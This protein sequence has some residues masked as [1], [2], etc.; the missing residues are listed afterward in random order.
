M[1]KKTMATIIHTELYN[2]LLELSQARADKK[3]IEGTEDDKKAVIKILADGL[4]TDLPCAV[5][6]EATDSSSL[7]FD[8]R[9]QTKDTISPEILR[10]EGVSE[11][12]IK[13]ATK[14]SAPFWV[15]PPIKKL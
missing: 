14:R 7:E 2:A 6:S 11:E 13:K 15:I 8:M 9:R 10:A 12:I 3:R 1:E 4:E 5:R